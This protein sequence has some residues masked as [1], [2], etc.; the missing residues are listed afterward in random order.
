[1]EARSQA[2]EAIAERDW[3][4]EVR[5]ALAA[6][7]PVRSV[8]VPPAAADAPRKLA[9]LTSK[10]VLYVA[11]VE[12]GDAEVPVALAAH[13]E[14]AGAASVAVSARI[15][16]DLTEL[17]ESEAAEMRAE[18]GLHESGLERLVHAA[19]ALLDLITFFTAD[20]GVDATARSLPRG[21][22]AYDA[23]G[24]V[25][26]DIQEGFVRAEVI[27]WEALVDAGDWVAASERGVIRTEGRDYVVADGDI[28]NIKH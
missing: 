2:K 4:Q 3:L 26:R 15:E 24:K 11:N 18:L 17:D 25:H 5:D 8:P 6:G 28:I 13:A 16:A 23:A 14:A 22:T 10:P 9:A 12:E 21:G 20:R 7:R 1:K 27:P 19:Y